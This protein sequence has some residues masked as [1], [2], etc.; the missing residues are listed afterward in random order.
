MALV[1]QMA[2]VVPRALE[3]QRSRL[4]AIARSPRPPMPL[5]PVPTR[6]TH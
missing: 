3:G 6:Q 2:R 1:A 5:R 4:P